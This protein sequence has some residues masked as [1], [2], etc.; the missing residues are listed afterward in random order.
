M[1][2]ADAP[3]SSIH[4]QGAGHHPQRRCVSSSGWPGAAACVCAFSG[5]STSQLRPWK[6][7]QPL[8][9]SGFGLLKTSRP[10]VAG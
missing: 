9:E 3:T 10:A 1:D 5:G 6:P 7:E 4:Q 8:P 2:S